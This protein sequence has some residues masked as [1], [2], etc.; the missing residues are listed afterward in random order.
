MW[1]RFGPFSHASGGADSSLRCCSCAC[2]TLQVLTSWQERWD[3][4]PDGV[5]RLN[6]FSFFSVNEDISFSSLV[7]DKRGIKSHLSEIR[8]LAGSGACTKVG[9]GE[10][11]VA[12]QLR[13]KSVTEAHCSSEISVPAPLPLTVHTNTH[14]H[15]HAPRQVPAP[16]PP[17]GKGPHVCVQCLGKKC[18][19][20]PD[21]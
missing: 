1:S 21:D 2:R 9:G 12:A 20:G 8:A 5:N 15:T 14:T 17:A 4:Q 19:L 18:G 10:L 3:L 16:R 13:A 11:S 6:V 7:G